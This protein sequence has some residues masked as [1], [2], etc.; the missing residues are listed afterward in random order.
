MHALVFRGVRDLRYEDVPTPECPADGA[1][2]RVEAVGI[3]GSDVHGYLGITGRRIPPMIMGHEFAGTI[4]ALGAAT[5]GYTV[6]DRV[7]VFPY[8]HCESCSAC[9]EGR[10]NAC[11]AK[12]FFGVLRTNGGMA[13]FAAVPTRV[14]FRLPD[15]ASCTHGALAEPLSVAARTVAKA[16]RQGSGA[17]VVIGAGPIG[18]LCLLLLH[19][20]GKKPVGVIDVN[21]TRLTLARDLGAEWAWNP[22]GRTASDL[23]AERLSAR[24]ADTVIEA[25]GIEATTAQ[26]IEIV[27]PGGKLVIVGMLEPRIVVDM[28]TVVSKEIRIESSF[29]YSHAEFSSVLSQLPT[30][31]AALDKIASRTAPLENGPELFA[32]LAAGAEKACKV[33]LTPD[34]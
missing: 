32:R 4:A 15:A 20:Q 12:Q 1:L 27:R 18:L 6:G 21:E 33:I 30:L 28:H 16:D 34:V 23:T 17:T 13:E 2:I 8:A 11:S 19:A 24:G 31:R 5:Q 29:L 22:Q 14:L 25:V 9:G 10:S 7:A 26:A 3:C